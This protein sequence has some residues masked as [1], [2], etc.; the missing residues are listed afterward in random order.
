MIKRSV[1][2]VSLFLMAGILSAC[3]DGGPSE[4]RHTSVEKSKWARVAV[5]NNMRGA[6]GQLNTKTTIENAR[7]LLGFELQLPTSTKATAAGP[8]EI[9]GGEDID[10]FVR[11]KGVAPKPDAPNKS[12][13][14]VEVRYPNGLKML[15]NIRHPQ[16]PTLNYKRP[17][18]LQ[19]GELLVGSET[20]DHAGLAKKGYVSPDDWE[21][22]VINGHQG[23]QIEK[24]W[25]FDGSTAETPTPDRRVEQPA[26]IVWYDDET[27]AQYSVSAPI[28]VPLS[29]LREVVE[30]IL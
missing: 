25:V 7:A 5:A 22:T 11:Q 28:G 17:G 21:R 3:A 4:A 10:D 26:T 12:G 8:V 30:S 2:F 23:M 27:W 20:I 16:D 14:A 15:V 19:T 24:S 13:A 18:Q 29:E 6:V 1:L 9:F